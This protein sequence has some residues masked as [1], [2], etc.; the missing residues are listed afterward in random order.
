MSIQTPALEQ[1]YDHL[2][3]TLDSIPESGRTPMLTRLA[4]LMSEQIGQQ[5]LICR[6]I[7]EAAFTD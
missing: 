2:A 4:L 1:V 5:D 7:D 6:L 3:E